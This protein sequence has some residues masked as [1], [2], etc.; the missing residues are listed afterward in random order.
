M[1]MAELARWSIPYPVDASRHGAFR[2]IGGCREVFTKGLQ[3]SG[4]NAKTLFAA[5]ERG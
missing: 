1:D 3:L 5:D 4:A 2:G